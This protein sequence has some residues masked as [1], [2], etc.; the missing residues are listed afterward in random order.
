MSQDSPK[1][2][3]SPVTCGSQKEKT[4]FSILT[5][6]IY[7]EVFYKICVIPKGKHLFGLS[8]SCE[9][10]KMFKSTFFA[11]HLGATASVFKV[12]VSQQTASLKR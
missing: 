3:G 2:L 8:L 10:C 7:L 4:R 5:E 12:C 1:L 9:F 6:A 11:E